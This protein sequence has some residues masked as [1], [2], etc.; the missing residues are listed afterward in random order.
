M[1]GLGLGLGWTSGGG[2]IGGGGTT[3]ITMDWVQ[4]FSNGTGALSATKLNN[5]NHGSDWG[6]WTEPEGAP[7]HTTIEDHD[8][9]LPIPF[10]AGGTEYDGSEGKGA[11]FDFATEPVGADTFRLGFVEV[12]S[13]CQLAFLAKYA[14]VLDGVS[15]VSYNCDM[16]VI[17]GADFTVPQR[18]HTFAN[19]KFMTAHTNGDLGAA[20]LDSG[21]WL[22]VTIY[23]DVTNERALMMVQEVVASGDTWVLG[24]L[25]GT[26]TSVHAAPSG[27]V[28]SLDFKD[29]LRPASGTGDI[30]VKIFGMR[31]S[32]LDWPMYNPGTIPPP[33][34]V[35]AAQNA[36]GEVTLTWANVCDTFLIERKTGSGS[37]STLEAEYTNHGTDSYTDST[38]ADATTYTYRVTTLVGTS[39]S[40]A[41]ESNPI[42]VD[43]TF[44]PAAGNV[45]WL[46]AD[47]LVLSDNDPVEIWEDD[48]GLGND[49][50]QATAGNRPTFKTNIVNGMPVVRGDGDDW[51]A[52]SGVV[53]SSEQHTI[54]IVVKVSGTNSAAPFYNGDTS[55]DGWGFFQSSGGDRGVLFGGS[56]LKTD[57][58]PSATDF[59]IQTHTWN[60]STSTLWVDGVEQV[61]TDPSFAPIA[62]S[63]DTLVM[64]LAGT[65]QWNGDVAEILVW[66]NVISTPAKDEAEAY[67]ALKYGITI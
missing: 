64:G 6:D 5:G 25:L 60:G 34:S 26:S 10:L 48:S 50:N 33:T 58:A 31:E 27:V 46:K 4:N 12:V 55:G 49:V 21:T 36:P 7:T 52:H 67:L 24:T 13:D 19:V 20:V 45:L 18:Q 8:V 39:S 23:H 44:T 63:G 53:T 17:A 40:S 57:G 28:T 38:V 15:P 37:Y 43:N 54:M 59:E 41:V 47:S 32:V 9:T 66:D 11:T 14:T 30:K 65:N 56:V 61:L 35:V 42:T 29:Y 1:I 2:G 51:L 62:P 16:F 3:P 22:L